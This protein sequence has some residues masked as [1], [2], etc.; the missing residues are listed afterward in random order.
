V[1]GS[2]AAKLHTLPNKCYYFKVTRSV[3]QQG[4]IIV[5][6]ILY[7]VLVFSSTP[8]SIAEFTARNEIEKC[9]QVA[10]GDGQSSNIKIIP[11]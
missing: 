3:K 6:T 5:G 4:S 1:V 10:V 9:R 7:P 11:E 8:N 2:D